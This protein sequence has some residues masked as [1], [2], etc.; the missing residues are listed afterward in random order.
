MSYAFCVLLIL[1]YNS[2]FT[3]GYLFSLSKFLMF[4]LFGRCF[5][6]TASWLLLSRKL[7]K[8]I[9]VVLIHFQGMQ[10]W[11]WIGGFTNVIPISPNIKRR[12][13]IALIIH[14]Q[15]FGIFQIIRVSIQSSKQSISW[16]L[17]CWVQKTK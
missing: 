1:E 16:L 4:C 8:D 5:S 13:N 15:L 17:C 14:V 11:V 2:V 10:A 3:S 6:V 7:W 9:K 12:V